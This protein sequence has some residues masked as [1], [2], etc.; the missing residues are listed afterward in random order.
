M[1]KYIFAAI[2]VVLAWAAVLVFHD[3]LPLWPAILVT[4][5][6]LLGLAAYVLWKKLDSKK[7]AS[8]IEKGLKDDA[9]RQNEG[10]RPDLQVEIAAMQAEFNRA[11][12]ALKSSK[13]GANGRDALGLLPWY[14]MIGPSASG[15]TTAIRSSGLKLPY[16]KGGK[17][18]GVGGTRNC[19]WW[20]TNEAILLDTAGR[21][22]TE[23]DDRDEWLAFLSLLKQTRPKK[24]INGI[25]LA[26]PVTDL[27][28][29]EEEIGELARTLRERVDEVVAHLETIVPVYVI[30]T[31]C[32]L[33]AG[34][35]ETFGEL[36]DRERGQIWGF[37][38]PLIK[39]HHDHVETFAQHFD[40]LGDV[41][42]RNALI[43][44]G[45]ERRLEARDKIYAFPQQFDSLR[46]GLIDLVAN[47]FDASVYHEAPIMR[48]V[49]F[50]SGTQEGRPI[51][52]I[53]D[54]MANA[55]GV[56]ARHAVQPP[57]KPKSYFVRDVFQ[58]VIFPDKDVAVRKARVLKRERYLRWA[59][60]AGALG[61]SAALLVLPVS[62]YLANKQ[63]VD[64][65]A[66]YVD[67][68]IHAREEKSTGGPLSGRIMETTE[69]TAARLA[70]FAE[71]GPDVALQF[72]ALYPGDRLMIPLH[73]A[74]ERLVV[75]PL[76]D[77]DIDRMVAFTRG[78]GE[79][80]ATGAMGS[81]VLH[82]LLTQPKSADEPSPDGDGWNSKW[83]GVAAQ[84]AGDRWSA[85]AGDGASN[86]ARNALEDAIR[87]YALDIDTSSELI[88]RRPKVVSVV[89]RALIGSNDGDPLTDLL[90]DPNMPRDVRLADIVGG[91]VTVFENGGERKSGPSVPGAFT[92]QGWEVA[93]HRIQRLA[94]SRAHDENSWVLGASRKDD[95]IDVSAL[96]S[97][98][99]RRYIDVWKA[100]LLTLSVKEPNSIQEVRHLLKAFGSDKPLDA[101][102]R[103][104]SRNLVWKEES[105]LDDALG[106]L[107]NTALGKKLADK[108][109]K[110]PG[111][112]LDEVNNRLGGP[113]GTSDEPQSPEDVGREFSTFLSFGLTKPTGLDT[114]GEILSEIASA[115]GESGSPDTRA[116]ATAVRDQRKK[117]TNLIA[118]YNDNNW[119]GPLLEKILMP[120]LRGAEVAVSGATGDSANR[121]WCDS[122][123]VVYDQLLAGKY[124][125]TGSKNTRDARV[126]DVDKFFQ[127]KTGTLWQ[128]Y[129]DT[130]AADFEHP[131]GT[132]VFH[133]RE[134]PSVPY[135]SNLPAFLKR[136]QE[137][138]DLLYGKEGGKIGVNVS[139]RIRASAPY[140]R[141]VFEMGGKKVSYIN[142]KERWEDLTWPARGALFHFYQKS[143][144]GELGYTDG[145]WA[146]FRF[147]ENGKFATSSEG[148]DYVAG[149]WTPPLGD[150]VIHADVKPAALL[151]AFHGLEFPRSIVAGGGSCS[152]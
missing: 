104:A 113:K 54:K 58:R 66:L 51:D 140:T 68:L 92:P 101:I 29:T 122:I 98:Y 69:A 106:M 7:T 123:V 91:A 150:G 129:N 132:S 14:V 84:K 117:L 60:A 97:A 26:V 142:S 138:T 80:D 50:S 65:A 108:K 53:M 3:V 100:F 10:I 4:V 151:R 12:G 35:V 44:M 67:R 135:R 20:M 103:N 1:L 15:K 152:K 39:E 21:W 147:L 96:K 146:L 30:V 17:V 6:I 116:F 32:D 42:E 81:L 28:K 55:F 120:P 33:V 118:H 95:T 46:Q 49:F 124:P 36:K 134:Q 131:A 27:Q 74:V 34:F 64:E 111:K 112:A 93:K 59:V 119:E 127:P 23:E 126:A 107:G 9:E 24:P 144:E 70:K 148:E 143:G 13:L 76:L 128:Y 2:F 63:F 79:T 110:I 72:S 77:F 85:M 87:F 57:T 105:P 86:H 48:G 37:T 41:L 88:E 141:I 114:Y 11:V 145:E 56:K 102:W 82:L 47:L 22:S 52:R 137:L 130:L 61:I 125:F 121:K 19:D 62:S 109:K 45:E 25:L 75:R 31:K 94:A 43:R 149:T 38:L 90:R 16:A 78:Q 83:V 73:L 139:I 40:E 5:L 18:R 115:V 8:A 99:F 133:V 89:R 136:A 71:K